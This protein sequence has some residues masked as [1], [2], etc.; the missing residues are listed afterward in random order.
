MVDVLFVAIVVLSLLAYAAVG[1]L[2]SQVRL[3][4]PS[5][6]QRRVVDRLGL[7]DPR[8]S[9]D[10]Q[11]LLAASHLTICHTDLARVRVSS[12]AVDVLHVGEGHISPVA[13]TTDAAYFIER[14]CRAVDYVPTEPGDLYA[15][16]LSTGRHELVSH[17]V[18]GAMPVTFG[19]DDIK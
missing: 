6:G 7:N 14:P 2:D 13:L 15:L 3:F 4:F 18:Y 17:L 16:W 5:T 11:D 19:P 8:W 10:G 12:L 1:A 9:E